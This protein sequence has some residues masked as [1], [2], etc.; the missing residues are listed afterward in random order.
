MNPPRSRC[1][2]WTSPPISEESSAAPALHNSLDLARHGEARGY[3]HHGVAEQCGTLTT[4][5][6]GHI[7][8]GL[9]R[10]PGTDRAAADKLI[11]AGALRQH[12]AR[13]HCYGLRAEVGP[14][15]QAAAP[16]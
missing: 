8:L 4:L 10:A 5:Q 12:A 14:A 2:S 16:A 13:L 3:R 7:D 1:P 15:S 6:P 9:A 11:V